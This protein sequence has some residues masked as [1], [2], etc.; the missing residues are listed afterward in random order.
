LSAG[1]RKIPAGHYLF[2][3][4]DPSD[5]MYVIKGGKLAVTKAK[6]N[7]E[8]V[9]A[10]LGPGAMVGEMAFFDGRPRSANVKAVKDAE[11]ICLPF[12]SLHAQFQSFPEWCKAVMR[13]VNDH[14]REAN[15]RIKTLEKPPGEEDLF[16]PHTINKLISIL[17]FV[18]MRYGKSTEEGVL[19]PQYTL[20]N[21]TIQIFQEATHKMEKMLSA[22]NDIGL[23]ILES[24]GEGKQKIVIKKPDMLFEFV[25]WHNEWLFKQEKDRI[26]IKEDELKILKA[27]VHFGQKLTPNDKGVVKLSLKAMQDE[28]MRELEF[29]VKVDDINSLI[30]KKLISDKIMEE[31]GIYVSFV[32]AD[33]EKIYP[34]WDLIYKLKRMTR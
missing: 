28:S 5:A 30:E 24:Q 23:I 10:E 7:S 26:L 33:L 14:L 19:V 31:T 21:Y 6:N 13:T 3:D 34:K 16:P 12:K 11:V 29:L 22:M 1:S 32:L 18:G 2:R 17:N 20:R 15:M 8:I 4:G 9:L 25:E 27:V